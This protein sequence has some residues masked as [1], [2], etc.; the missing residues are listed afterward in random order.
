[1]HM[2]CV[3]VQNLKFCQSVLGSH[4]GTEIM[5]ALNQP[6]CRTHRVKQVHAYERVNAW[7]CVA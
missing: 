3:L 1:M 7:L 5:I 4:P 2:D 6:C